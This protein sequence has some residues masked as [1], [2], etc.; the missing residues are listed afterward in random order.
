[1]ISRARVSFPSLV[2]EAEAQAAAAA[3]PEPWALDLPA[4]A[5]AALPPDL[6]SSG[7]TRA[8]TRLVSLLLDQGS[9]GH[10]LEWGLGPGLP[11]FLRGRLQSLVSVERDGA[12]AAIAQRVQRRHA[13]PLTKR[14]E[15]QYVPLPGSND[16]AHATG[17]RYVNCPV[18]P[19]AALRFISVGRSSRA[20]VLKRAVG[21]LRPVDG[22]LV[23]PDVSR[24]EAL[25]ARSVVPPHWQWHHSGAAAR[26]TLVFLSCTP[27][28]CGLE[29]VSG[30]GWL[31]GGAGDWGRT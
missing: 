9:S 31:E 8:A 4:P 22:V 15:V 18:P 11:F 25:Q 12:V 27:E 10:G 17:W 2:R 5:P 24:E 7:F 19:D 29:Q 16:T 21:I 28:A 13:T 1:M 6:C 23:L 14:W 26:G 3:C 30:A 20:A